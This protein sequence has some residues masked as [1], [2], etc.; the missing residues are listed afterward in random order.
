MAFVKYLSDDSH[1][2]YLEM[3]SEEKITISN[4][5]LKFV[6]KKSYLAPNENRLE[7]EAELSDING[8]DQIEN[9]FIEREE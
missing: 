3:G 7:E 8:I 6:G 1:S 9:E 4:E 5:P 2:F